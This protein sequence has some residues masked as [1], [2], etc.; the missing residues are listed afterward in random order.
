MTPAL[1]PATPEDDAFLFALYA[2]TRAE[3]LDAWGLSGPAREAF[4]R[5]QFTAQQQHYRAQLPR[6]DHQIILLDGAPAGRLLVDRREDESASRTSPCCP[7]T[8]AAAWGRR[9]SSRCS[10]RRE[11]RGRCACTC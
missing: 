1:R 7:S 6:A 10:R 4:L 9:C 2:S 11:R 5:M 8:G 3:E